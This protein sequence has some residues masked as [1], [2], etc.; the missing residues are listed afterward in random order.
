MPAVEAERVWKTFDKVRYVLEDVSLSVEPGEFVVLMGPSGSGKST[1]VNLLAGL[2]HPT[3][4]RLLVGGIDL[5]GLSEDARTE[6]RLHKIGLVF[7]RFHLIPELTLEENVRLPMR[8]AKR[9]NANRRAQE[10]L[11]FF[12]LDGQARAF[13]ST[14]SGGETQ[15]GAIARALANEPTIVLA[16]EPTANLDDE[17]AAN[18]LAELRRV[19]DDL[20]T[21]II[22][23]THD[24]LAT[25][26]GD[27]VVY[28]EAG[29]I[30]GGEPSTSR[31]DRA[32]VEARSPRPRS[33]RPDR[34]E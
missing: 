20:Q 10:L 34:P 13:P 21:A 30:A 19:A 31:R 6:A 32:G 4:G 26:Y 3:R 16:D 14:L 22:V 23:A 2:D 9:K 5:A 25:R 29:R 33:R 27:R 18:A 28:L 17:N 1:L 12:G 7:Q 11:K 8:F 24:A 15:R